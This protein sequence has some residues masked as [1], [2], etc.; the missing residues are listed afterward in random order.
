MRNDCP[1]QWLHVFH[2]LPALQETLIDAMK[3]D[4]R[5]LG[6]KEIENICLCFFCNFL[7]V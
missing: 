3:V 1:L 7:C 6:E 2:S 4:G 5:G